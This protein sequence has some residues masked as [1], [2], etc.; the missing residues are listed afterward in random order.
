MQR[1]SFD[2]EFHVDVTA[3][4]GGFLAEV[5]QLP[6]CFAGGAT[7]EEAVSTLV[8]IIPGYLEAFQNAANVVVHEVREI[9]GGPDESEDV[10]AHRAVLAG[11]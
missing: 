8:E 9:Q 3:E 11:V 2:A 7:V 5:R 4:D 6:G 10:V 1:L